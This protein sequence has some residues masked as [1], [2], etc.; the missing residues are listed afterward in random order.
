MTTQ[1]VKENFATRATSLSARLQDIAIEL[2]E[3]RA[4]YSANAFPT[5]GAEAI[6]QAELD[7]VQPHLTPTLLGQLDNALAAVSGALTMSHRNTLRK[8]RGSL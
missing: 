1:K 5:G 3:F 8:C 6:T 4:F 2:D 7:G